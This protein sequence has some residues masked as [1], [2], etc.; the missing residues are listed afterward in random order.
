M[1]YSPDP[2]SVAILA[3]A[4]FAVIAIRSGLLCD[5]GAKRLYWRQLPRSD[6]SR[7]SL[8]VSHAAV[9]V[10]GREGGSSGRSSESLR[11]QKWSYHV[12]DTPFDLAYPSQ[13]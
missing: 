2:V 3:Q 10:P 12:G 7:R 6:G 11:L 1:I 13:S 8:C 5:Q 9:W 4:V